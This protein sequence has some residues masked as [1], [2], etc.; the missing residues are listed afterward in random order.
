MMDKVSLVRIEG[1]TSVYIDAEIT[2]EGDLLFSGQDVG[3]APSEMFGDSDYEYW[4]MIPALHKDQ[5]SDRSV[6]NPLLKSRRE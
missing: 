5:N 3:E 1:P 4:L 6:V 2:D